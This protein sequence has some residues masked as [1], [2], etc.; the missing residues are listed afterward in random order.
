[1]TTKEKARW[2]HVNRNN[3]EY[4]R[5]RK[6]LLFAL[7]IISPALIPLAISVIMGTGSTETADL[8][9]RSCDV[10]SVLLA[11]VAFEI[12]ARIDPKNKVAHRRIEAF[13]KYFTGA[14][15]CVSAVIMIFI[16]ING[17][18]SEKS[19]VTVSFILALIAAVTNAVL[20]FNYRSMKNS[21]LSVQAKNHFVKMFFNILVSIILLVWITVPSATARSYIDL[22]GSLFISGYL[23]LNGALVMIDKEVDEGK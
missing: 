7:F 14:A 3:N 2:K 18:G 23:F 22:I 21:I 15:M 19:G 5:G 11:Y 13:V 16:S 20:Y 8:F 17:F 10:L 12:S 4:K 6:K 1:M 9:R